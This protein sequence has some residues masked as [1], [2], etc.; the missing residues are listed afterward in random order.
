M[1]IVSSSIVC[2]SVNA[3]RDQQ[4]C[5][6]VRV[7]VYECSVIARVSVSASVR[8]S[9]SALERGEGEDER[10]IKG[11]RVRKTEREKQ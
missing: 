11:E 9:A 3:K 4:D 2:I 5:D 1:Q 10:G 7:C 8:V 6:G